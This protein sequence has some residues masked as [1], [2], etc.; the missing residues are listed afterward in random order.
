MS[1]VHLCWMCRTTEAT[2][3]EH[4][5]PASYFR[6][7]PEAWNELVHGTWDGEVFHTQGVGSRNLKNFV[8]CAN[9]NNA[10]S[11][12]QDRALDAFLVM[13][14]DHHAEVVAREYLDVSHAADHDPLDLY[15]A[16]IKLEFSRLYAD[17]VAVPDAVANFVSGG[18]DWQSVNA[19][20]R[21]QFRLCLNLIENGYAYPSESDGHFYE[22]PY[23]IAHQINFGWL[24]VH[25]IYA[26]QERPDLPWWEWSMGRVP[27]A[28]CVFEGT[29]VD[30]AL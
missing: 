6:R 7:I 24:G 26:P 10:V 21:I 1:E 30:P 22:P 25:Y 29:T 27:L 4:K 28:P 3:G 16:L 18:D 12:D 2:T 19:L 9:C 17:G 8:L 15:R 5:W 23:F 20:V 13:L 11:R 14:A